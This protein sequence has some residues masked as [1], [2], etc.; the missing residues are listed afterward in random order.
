LE[1]DA[2]GLVHETRKIIKLQLI[3][4]VLVAAG[5]FL[6][7]GPWE[8]VSA[9]YGGLIS[10]ISALI[11]RWGVVQAG[12]AVQQGEKNRGEV[13]LY[14]G[15]AIRFVLVLVLFGVGLAALKLTPLATVMG[16]IAVQLVF[17]YAARLMKQQ[18]S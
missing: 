14:A 5:Y 4:G 9:L 11:L 7:Y 10:A 16:F 3:V 13:I 15:A 2:Q 18:Q 6:A 17:L 1:T 12:G 8:A